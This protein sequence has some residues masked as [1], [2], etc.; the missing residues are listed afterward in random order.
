MFLSLFPNARV[1]NSAKEKQVK[2]EM[3][4]DLNRNQS[5]FLAQLPWRTEIIILKLKAT[6]L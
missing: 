1:Q 6:S 4:A 3:M 2:V 5:D